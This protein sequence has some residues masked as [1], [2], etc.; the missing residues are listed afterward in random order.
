[1]INDLSEPYLALRT[2]SIMETLFWYSSSH[3]QFTELLSRYETQCASHNTLYDNMLK[4]H[5]ELLQW[6][7]NKTATDEVEE[8]K[9]LKEETLALKVSG[10]WNIW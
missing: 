10:T 7:R 3:S 6:F 4:E 5:D 8:D 9:K 1:M 2:C